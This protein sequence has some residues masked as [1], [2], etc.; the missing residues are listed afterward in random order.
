MAAY[1]KA[2]AAG[3]MA[4]LAWL[5]QTFGFEIPGWVG[6]EALS[7]LLLALAPLV[8]WF[9]PNRDNDR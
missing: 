2:I 9:V 7:S 4:L 1:A 3:V 8:V 5:S 6:E